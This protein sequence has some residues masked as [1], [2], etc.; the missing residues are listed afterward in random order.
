MWCYQHDSVQLQCFIIHNQIKPLGAG[1]SKISVYAAQLYSSDT[2]PAI[3]WLSIMY[4]AYARAGSNPIWPEFQEHRP[5]GQQ[6][7]NP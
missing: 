2:G 7:Y 3:K 6:Y 4:V 1:L 5:S